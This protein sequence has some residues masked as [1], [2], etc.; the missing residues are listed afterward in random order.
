MCKSCDMD[1]GVG[2]LKLV[3]APHHHHHDQDHCQVRE[4]ELLGIA[5]LNGELDV[6]QRQLVLAKPHQGGGPD[7]VLH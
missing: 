1:M 3:P 4:P 7:H 6:L 2:G 5:S